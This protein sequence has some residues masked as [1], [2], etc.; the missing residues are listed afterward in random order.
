MAAV[1]ADS[2]VL[3]VLEQVLEA[4]NAGDHDRLAAHLSQRPDA[5]HIGSDA[6]EWWTSEELVGSF[7]NEPLGIKVVMD[8]VSVRS[9]TS[10]VAWAVGRGRFDNESGRIRPMRMTAVLVR[11]A[12]AWKVVHLHASIGVPNAELFG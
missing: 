9:E 4:I 5:L 12:G 2:E 6:D 7:G 3:G 10:S 8:D 11:E 1:G